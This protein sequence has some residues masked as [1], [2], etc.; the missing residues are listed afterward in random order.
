MTHCKYIEICVLLCV[1]ILEMLYAQKLAIAIL[2]DSLY[3]TVSFLLT[4]T[5]LDIY[6]IFYTL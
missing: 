4:Y 5:T 3:L 1:D 2:H 6:A